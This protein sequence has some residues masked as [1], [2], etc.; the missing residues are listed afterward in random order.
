VLRQKWRLDALLGLGGMAAVY[1]ATHR[2]GS[3]GAVKVLHPELAVDRDIRQ[4]FLREGY[5]ANQVDHPGVVRVLDDDEDEGTVFLVME[6][7]EGETLEGRRERKGGALPADEVLS[8][9]DQ[10]LDALAA[11]HAK[12][13]IH[14]DIKPENV[15]LTREG[16]VK[17]LDFGIARIRQTSH[18]AATKTGAT[19]GTPAFM[20]PEHARGRW[21]EVDARS[22]VFAIGATL[23]TLASGRYV[24]DGGTVNEVLL[25]AMTQPAPLLLSVA[26]HAGSALAAV[27]DR[28]LAFDKADRWPDA[29]AMQQAVRQAFHAGATADT[30]SVAVLRAG[31]A[32]D[33]PPLAASSVAEGPRTA[34]GV[35]RTAM[36]SMGLVRPRGVPWGVLAA[37]AVAA[38]LI[39]VLVVMGRGAGSSSPASATAAASVPVTVPAKTATDLPPSPNTP[40]V[41][42]VPTPA[43]SV[44]SVESLPK[45]AV[46]HVAEPAPRVVRPAVPAT[47]DRNVLLEMLAERQAEKPVEKPVEKPAPPK[48]P[49][50]DALDQLY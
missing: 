22:D 43:V 31:M 16:H 18:T 39:T 47:E 14:R 28:A 15:F 4:R 17:V 24:H 46:P 45:E 29:I 1:A 6:L 13:I 9:A 50:K 38:V 12:G 44:L 42:P 49:K 34:A 21:D 11:A 48:K 35:S 2:N 40:V 25:S 5:V 19:M 33:Q 7:L 36:E 41:V 3:R 30:S 37:V 8:V 27:V 26:P 32:Q 10:L 20:S 23:F